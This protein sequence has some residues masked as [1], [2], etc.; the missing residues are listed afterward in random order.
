MTEGTTRVDA[1]AEARGFLDQLEAAIAAKDL[2]AL[3]ALCT[4][5]VALFG[6]SRAN[7]GLAE[8]N[9]YLRLVADANTVR[10]FLTRWSVAHHDE[11]HL[12]VAAEGQAETDDGS[13]TERSAFRLTLWLVRHEGGWRL[14][15]FHGSVPQG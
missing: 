11:D 7:F 15:H 9:D 14:G 12:L 5:D 8:S 13:N 10:W 2:A 6:S 1:V 3:T 4:E